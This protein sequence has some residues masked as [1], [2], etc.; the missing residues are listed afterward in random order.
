MGSASGFTLRLKS[1]SAEAAP[2][3]SD[4]VSSKR[5][6][7]AR[8]CGAASE[9]SSNRLRYRLAPANWPPRSSSERLMS[10]PMALTPTASS[11]STTEASTR[12]SQGTRPK[13]ARSE[14]HT[15]ELQSQ[16]NLVCRLLLEKKKDHEL[17]LS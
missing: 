2:A 6:I 7:A 12:R 1:C 8:F 15:S 16:S 4:S 5:S 13:R 17:R 14:E 11:L 3:I 9:T 10:R